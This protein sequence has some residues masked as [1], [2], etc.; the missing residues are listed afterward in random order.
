MNTALNAE[1][2]ENV[3]SL[4]IAPKPKTKPAQRKQRFKVTEFRNPS[5]VLAFR[6]SG[7]D[8]DGKQIRENFKDEAGARCRQ[9][10]LEYE[11]LK[12]PTE[13]VIRATKLTEDQLRLAERAT[14]IMQE[15]WPRLLEAVE[16]WKRSGAKSLPIESPRI[17]EAVDQYLK[18]LA[19]S[20]L[21]DTTK[22]HWRNRITVFKNSVP[23]A[24][25]SDVRPDDIWAFMD[26]R[27]IS[28]SGKNA[29]RSAVSK[30]FSWSIERPRRWINFNPCHSVT[31]KQTRNGH[32]DILS[33][34]DCKALLHAA[35]SHKDGLMA[36]YVTVC[37]FGGLRP[38]EAARL[39]WRQINLDDGEIRIDATQSKT[40]RGRIV[41]ICPTLAAWLNAHQGKPFYPANWRKEFDAVKRMAGL[42]EWTPDILRHTAISHYFRQTGSYGFTAE[43]F[44]NSEAIIKNHY[45]G[46]VSTGETKSFYAMM[47]GEGGGK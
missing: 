26:A 1:K 17:D 12:T 28:A 24:R 3:V 32:P 23:N 20:D 2:A 31:I 11:Y 22:K 47:P 29:Y 27:K 43:Q 35:E 30:F 4:V 10:E 6:V 33:L 8:R 41:K 15:D 5:G 42:K 21:R 39:D 18:W 44:G 9:I 37:L 19:A 40:K 16:Q 45:Q 25:L 7:C 14:R 36:A 38:T 34:T 13:T 46:R